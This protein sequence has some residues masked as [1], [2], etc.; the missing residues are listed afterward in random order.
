MTTHLHSYLLFPQ[1][2]RFP[3]CGAVVILVI[4]HGRVGIRAVVGFGNDGDAATIA[5]L[6]RSVD[7]QHLLHHCVALPLKFLTLCRCSPQTP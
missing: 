4:L 1:R 2:E 7:L 6:N 5:G 3:L